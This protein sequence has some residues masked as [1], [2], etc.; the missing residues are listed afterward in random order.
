MST[1]KNVSRRNLIIAG[2]VGAAVIVGGG[3]AYFLTSRPSSEPAPAPTPAPPQ[4]SEMDK[5]I[6]AAKEEGKLTIYTDGTPASALEKIDKPFRDKFGIEPRYVPGRGTALIKKALEEQKAGQTVAD[7]MAFTS[8]PM[9]FGKEND[10]F[11]PYVSPE[12]QNYAPDDRYGELATNIGTSVSSVAMYNTD[13]VKP[14]DVPKSWDELLEPKWKGKMVSPLSTAFSYYLLGVKGRDYILKL[15]DNELK[16]N[17]SFT[18]NRELIISGAFHLSLGQTVGSTLFQKNK[19]AP[20][21][22][23]VFEPIWGSGRPVSLTKEAPHPNAG[24]LFI[25]WWL[26]K[27]TMTAYLN[28]QPLKPFRKDVEINPQYNSYIKDKTEF[29][30]DT[31]PDVFTGYLTEATAARDE[32]WDIFGLK[33]RSR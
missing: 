30:W 3:A 2:G 16:A 14:E 31:N 24:K 8:N 19:G 21:D 9:W 22:A 10:M 5:L 12:K 32:V 15:K 29:V 28:E 6:E 33:R 7:V 26:S 4:M 13:L 25:D 20:V 1:G 17:P 11:Q 23:V 27:E 18:T